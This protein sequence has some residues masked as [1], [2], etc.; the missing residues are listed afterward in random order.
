MKAAVSSTG[1]T[2]DAPV[3]NL[4]G[5]C[6][7][8]LIIDTN[9]E[10]AT[11]IKNTFIDAAAG[12]GTGCAQAVLKEGAE[13]VISGQ[14]GPNAYEALKAAGVAM[15]LAPPG[16]SVREAL[17]KFKAGSLQKNEVRRF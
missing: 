6:D 3:H 17:V 5:R 16:V 8:I 4:F 9:T 2:L 12:A 13:A 1:P 10:A 11:P 14:I 7:F 15:Y